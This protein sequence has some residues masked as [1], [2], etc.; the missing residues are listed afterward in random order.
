MSLRKT[1]AKSSTII[2]AQYNY[3]YDVNIMSELTCCVWFRNNCDAEVH[4]QTSCHHLHCQSVW[5]TTFHQS[6]RG[7]TEANNCKVGKLS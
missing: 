4:G 5:L 6:V 1:D 3:V 2:L 7:L